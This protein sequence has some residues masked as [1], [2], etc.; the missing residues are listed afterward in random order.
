MCIKKCFWFIANLLQKHCSKFSRFDIRSHCFFKREKWK[1]R[2]DC[3]KIYLGILKSWNAN[4]SK[5]SIVRQLIGFTSVIQSE[6]N[7][8]CKT[9]FLWVTCHRSRILNLF[10]NI[11]LWKPW[12]FALNCIILVNS[13]KVKTCVFFQNAVTKCLL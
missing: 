3:R 1:N 2:N 9:R 4:F 13:K 8:Q 12:E 5:V 10:A 7:K 6:F 11:C